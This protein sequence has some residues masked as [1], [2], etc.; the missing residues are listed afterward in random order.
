MPESAKNTQ[1][2][3]L[4]A[5]KRA[6]SVR[7]TSLTWDGFA[8]LAG[9]DPRAFKTYRMPDGSVDYRVMPSLAR[10]AI[11]A[12]LTK[13]TEP[14]APA[15]IAHDAQSHSAVLLPALAALVVRQG[16]NSL[17]EKRMVAGIDKGAGQIGLG[18]EDRR[19]MAL[20]SR[21]CLVNGLEDQGAEIHNLLSLCTRPLGQWLP[22]LEVEKSGL[23]GTSFIQAEEGIPTPEA[24]EL[25]ATFSG[26]TQRLEEELFSNLVERLGKFPEG[27]AN[28]Y[29]TKVRE[30][31][32]RNPVCP[33]ER[34]KAF[35]DK[36][37]AAIWIVLHQN[38]Y[39][40]VPD[41]WAIAPGRSVPIC[42]HCGNAMR[43]RKAGYECRTAAC[44]AFA[45]ASSTNSAK[46][47]GLL[48]VTRG[49]R[50][51]WVEPGIDEMR[52]YDAL[53]AAGLHAELYPFRDRVDV[54]VGET[55]IDLKTYS[56]PETLG[57]RFKRGIGGLVYYHN[58]WL[59]VPDWLIKSVPSYLE[60]LRESM[61]ESDV[62]CMSLSEARDRLVKKGL[63]H[64]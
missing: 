40:A 14:A 19:A 33:T 3:W 43:A 45:G 23:S 35:S 46:N 13:G 49:I 8:K 55:G 41:S 62:V 6:L 10:S 57:L 22:I 1:K 37:P 58:R 11:E 24:D 15:D 28:N 16:R 9:I 25:A 48:R 18:H 26:L 34:L 39:E 12:L 21:V 30:F 7:H 20:V 59:V 4:T 52:L 42:D 27:V 5:A 31:V 53:T 36:L 51:Y 47:D 38:F 56:S 29:Y 44:A 17:I 32:V 60:R 2:L 50:Q 54:A 63:S 64:A 61:G